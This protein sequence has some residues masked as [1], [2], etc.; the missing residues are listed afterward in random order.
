MLHAVCINLTKDKQS[1]FVP[2]LRIIG[3]VSTANSEA[4]VDRLLWCG[5]LQSLTELMKRMGDSSVLK[6]CCFSLSN[7]G[8]GSGQ[9]IEKLVESEAFIMLIDIVLNTKKIA[10]RNEAL[11]AI[12]NAVTGCESAVRVR[13]I[14]VTGGSVI[15]ALV[16]GCR[17]ENKELALFKNVIEAIDLMLSLDKERDW[18]RTEHAIA[19]L[20]E[21]QGG[22][23]ALEEVQKH[24]DY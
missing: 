17:A 23:D 1:L 24:A 16:I 20:F 3:S 11:W 6:E 4:V 7:I 9:Q 8:A 12:C 14:E 21:R 5:V 2:A 10:N 15:A 18:Q 19:F 13:M 22:I